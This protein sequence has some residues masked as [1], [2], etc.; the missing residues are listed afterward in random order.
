[1]EVIDPKPLLSGND[2]QKLLNVP[3]GP[4]IGYV[5]NALIEAQIR[6]SVKNVGE[7][8]LFVKQQGQ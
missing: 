6:G 3:A 5:K 8:E 7:A 2:I 4:I 1:M